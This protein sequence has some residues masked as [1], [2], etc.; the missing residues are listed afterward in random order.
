L[1]QAIKEAISQQELGPGSALPS[2]RELAKQYH[3]SPAT[4]LRAFEQLS[5]QGYVETSPKSGTRVA[6]KFD[7]KARRVL[8]D[9][10]DNELTSLPL[11]APEL[12]QWNFLNMP[13]ACCLQNG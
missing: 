4:V 12:S 6:D 8:K 5:S 10:Q 3:L 1:S 11:R 7:I 9:K 13:C 2:A